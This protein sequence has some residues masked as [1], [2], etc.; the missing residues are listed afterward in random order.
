MAT[1]VIIGGHGK[2]ALLLAPLQVADKHRVQS[3][4]RTEDQFDDI[5]AA[6]AEPVLADVET[7][8]VAAMAEALTGADVVVWSAGAGGGTR[9][10]RT[11]W[12][13]TPRSDRWKRPGKP[14]CAGT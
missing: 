13:V 11:Q 6:G 8:D 1:I 2:V 5:R 7:M 10:G 14:G 9:P 4:V 3:W 12:T